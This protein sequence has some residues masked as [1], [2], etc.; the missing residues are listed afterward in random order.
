MGKHFG[1]LLLIFSLASTLFA[2]QQ[3]QNSY[4]GGTQNSSTSDCSD[5]LLASTSQCSSQTTEDTNP[6]ST[7]QNRTAPSGEY[8]TQPRNNNYSDSVSSSRQAAGRNQTLPTTLPPEPLTEFQKFIAS[9]TNEILPIF[10]ADLFRRVPSTFAP[11][12]MVPV[13][14]DYVIGPDDE[15]R[16]RIWGQV[17]FQ[18][19]VR[20][21]RSGEIYLPQVGP[22]HVSGMPFS[23][24]DAHLRGA[25]GRVYRN[26]DLT[27]D[28]GQIRA[29]QVYVAGAARRAG[30][31]T[32]SSLSTLVDTLFVSGGPSVHG[33]L[34]H[35]QLRRGS[36]V[37]T[38]F[39]LYNLLIHGDKSKDV[40]LQ[41][42]DVIFIPPAGSQVAVTGSVRN[43]AIYELRA[44]E[45]L[46][47]LLADAGGVSA[48]ALRKARVLDRAH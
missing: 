12:D 28:V 35:I 25:I 1:L 38:D 43:P 2:Q 32:V 24:L 30:V 14:P 22:V 17:N 11:L 46:A 10:G 16:I 6:L 27:V 29:I 39:D 20:V 33:S 37:I 15:L 40:K 44:N 8:G 5:P 9:T 18:A 31:Y 21:D 26:F 48:V 45:S 19:N 41:S 13:P 3:P 23:E 7:P 42:G 47:D 36:E 34:R 4:P